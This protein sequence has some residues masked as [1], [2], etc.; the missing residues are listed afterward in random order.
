MPATGVRAP[1]FTFVAVRAIAP[2]AGMP[3]KNGE[4]IFAMPCA[5]SSWFESCLSSIIP[6]ATTADS[7]DS[8]AA[9]IAIV[10]AGMSNC[11]ISENSNSGIV[12][13]GNEFGISPNLAKTV[14]VLK[15]EIDTRIVVIKIAPSMPGTRLRH[16]L[17]QYAII[18]ME[19]TPTSS[20]RRL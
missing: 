7:S 1:F 12:K 15:P 10:T 9:R 4:T 20:V 18:S 8:I 19:T 17:G 13:A 6:S 16:A 5:I 11:F 14:G 2:V 3:R